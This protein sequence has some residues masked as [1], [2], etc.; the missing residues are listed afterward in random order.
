MLF[1]SAY[2]AAAAATGLTGHDAPHILKSTATQ[3][4]YALGN[5]TGVQT[6]DLVSVHLHGLSN[7]NIIN[8]ANF[9]ASLGGVAMQSVLA[10]QTPSSGAFPGS[11]AFRLVTATSGDLPLSVDLGISARAALAVV[12]VIKGFD[13]AAPIGQ[14]F[15]PTS[16]NSDVATLSLP[17][18][19]V[20][21]SRNGNVYLA[22]V[23]IKGGVASALAISAM[24]GYA[25]TNTGIDS[26]S[27]LTVVYGWVKKS[28]V[29]LI[30]PVA[31]WTGAN[32]VSSLCTEIMSA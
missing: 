32:R 13:A 10:S 15:A 12:T 23:N 11:A 21:M 4:I 8:G 26:S 3:Q 1:P 30:S 17:A 25:S 20:T 16:L 24:D 9:T 2:I 14:T 5:V 19:G 6:G 18:A 27:D 7:A 22:S 28:P 29:G 31:T